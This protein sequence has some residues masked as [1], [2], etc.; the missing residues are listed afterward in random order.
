MGITAARIDGWMR[1]ARELGLITAEGSLAERVGSTPGVEALLYPCSVRRE[2]QAVY[3]LLRLDGERAL[4]IFG[5][6]ECFQGFSGQ[7]KSLRTS[8]Q[9][10]FCPLE[11][12][13]A[14]RLRRVLPFTAPSPLSGQAVTF[15]LGDRLGLAGPGHIQII[16]EY[17]AAPILAQQSVRE[18]ELTG[19]DYEQVLDA[20]TWAVFQ[21]GYILPWGADGDHL[22]SEDWVRKALVIGFTMIT[23][24]VSEHIRKQYA[25]LPEKDIQRE[26]AALDEG[27]RR[28]IED[29]Y[30]PIRMLLDSN[31]V[32]AFTRG[33]LARTALVYRLALEHAARLYR[34]GVEVNREGGFDFELSVDETDTPTTPEAHAFIALEARAA[35]IQVSSLAPR[36]VG[37]FQKG[38]DY[39][40]EV[41]AFERSLQTHAALA[42]HLGHRLSIHSGSDKLA[43]FPII[44]RLTGGRFHIKTSGTSWLEALRLIAAEEPA[45]YRTLHHKARQGYDR[46]ARYYHVTPN[47][48]KLP[49]ID[50]LRDDQLP[51][52]LDQPDTRQL[53]HITYGELLRDKAFRAGFFDALQKHIGKYWAALRRHIGRHLDLLGV[54]NR[55]RGA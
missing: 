7:R 23:A 5:P 2:K 42:R 47:L 8:P 36:F 35:G 53:L 31:D 52:L 13:N 39:I 41:Q 1:H 3:A 4:G 24:D 12:G 43:V 50:R 51:E 28:R 33:T 15:G 37:E 55:D 22:K 46:A 14:E 19:R 25:A 20:S 26:Y 32:V 54:P 27:Y 10:L 48:S 17:A 18:L 40:G 49:D 29:R 16:S 21:E 9:G 44:G 38:I 34:A 6:A 45:L 30:L 11:H